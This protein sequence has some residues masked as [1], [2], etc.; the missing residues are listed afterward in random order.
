MSAKMCHGFCKTIQGIRWL[1]KIH[2]SVLTHFVLEEA[3]EENEHKHTNTP[4]WYSLVIKEYH[5]G[6]THPLKMI[7]F[8]IVW[9]S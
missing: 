6:K 9:L 2:M 5:V 4:K 1:A 3:D 8:H 7:D